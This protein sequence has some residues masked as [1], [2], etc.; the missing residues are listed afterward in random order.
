MNKYTTAYKKQTHTHTPQAYCSRS[1]VYSGEGQKHLRTRDSGHDTSLS[2]QTFC[3]LYDEWICGASTSKH[4]EDRTP[5]LSV[6]II[7]NRTVA[8]EI[9]AGC[10]LVG[11]HRLPGRADRQIKLSQ[12]DPRRRI[13]SAVNVPR[14]SCILPFGF[15]TSLVCGF[16][17]RT[18]GGCSSV[19]GVYTGSYDVHPLLKFNFLAYVR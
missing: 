17:C 6:Q 2:E 12:N 15:R 9:T 1:D 11:G 19:L 7:G 8:V 10:H 13:T 14:I 5:S 16:Q 18:C 4:S 3:G